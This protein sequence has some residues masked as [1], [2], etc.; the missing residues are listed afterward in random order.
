VLT[1]LIN[2]VLEK[3]IKNYFTKT[4]LNKWYEKDKLNN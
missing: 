1:N 3:D 2:F 4:L